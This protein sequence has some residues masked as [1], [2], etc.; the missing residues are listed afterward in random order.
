M[1]QIIGID[2]GT[3]NTV[4]AFMDGEQPRIIP[5]DRGGHL[6]P[7]ICSITETG[8]VLVGESAKNQ[9][10]VNA[11]RT[12]M[13]VKRS[14]GDRESIRIDGHDYRPEEISGLILGHI[15]SYAERYLGRP[16]DDAV[17]T[18]PARFSE[19]ARRAT[20]EAGRRA[21]LTVHRILNEPTAAALAY[22]R[23]DA[24]RRRILV[25]DF[26]GGTFD[27][28]CLLQHGT[29][30]TVQATRGNEYLGGL[31]FDQLIQQ[32]VIESF[33]RDYGLS[34]ASDA[35]LLQQVRD[36]VERAKIELS[37]RDSALV[38][39]PF[40][41]GSGKPMHLRYTVTRQELNELIEDHVDR[42]MELTREALKDSGFE[43]GKVDNLV[44]AGGSTRIPRVRERLKEELG[45]EETALVNPDEI[46][47]LGAA[48]QAG[49]L[50]GQDERFRLT[51]VMSHALG[52]EIDEDQ[53]VTVL[54]RNS[55]LPAQ[56][57]RVFTTVSDNQKSVEINIL[58]GDAERASDNLSLGKFMLNGIRAGSRGEPKI[59]VSFDVDADGIAHVSARDV[60]TGVAQQVTVTTSDDE[61]LARSPGALQFRVATL[62]ERISGL[63]SRSDA[64]LDEEFRREIEELLRHAKRL[65]EAEKVSDMAKLGEYR[66][67]L[68][69]VMA[70]LNALYQDMEVGNEGA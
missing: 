23:R 44:L 24:D 25:Y 20:R 60:D 48:V 29:D 14:M 6:T 52:V 64:Y 8:D 56:A 38:A 62:V 39:M 67:A 49:M 10:I 46:V 15:K 11:E 5:N 34:V 31:D 7:S 58:Q 47:A 57:K 53:Y 63:V 12:V 41:G 68:E 65:A 35:I 70:E 36:L 50:S 59:E 32:K 51:D 61:E 3:T 45:L 1:S 19:A 30:F 27:V 21:G 43:A 26:G 55:R 16:V 42:T 40:I 17:I 69:A 54:E 2:L 66:V 13:H 28:T 9:A 37:S 33:E 4:A 18:V 22:A